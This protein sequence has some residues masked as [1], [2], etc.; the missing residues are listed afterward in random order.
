M[1]KLQQGGQHGYTHILI[2]TGG[3]ELAQ[4][5]FDH[6][7][8]LAK[9]LGSKV[10]IITATEPFP[11]PTDSRRTRADRDDDRERSGT[12][13]RDA[14]QQH[15][16]SVGAAGATLPSDQCASLPTPPAISIEKQLTG[17]SGSRAGVAEPGE[18]L[19]YT[20]TLTNFRRP[21]VQLAVTDILDANVT[22][23]NASDGGTLA[24]RNVTWTGLSVPG[25]VGAVPGTRTLV[26]RTKVNDPL[27]KGVSRVSNLAVKTGDPVPLCP[28]VAC[29]E[30]PTPAEVTVDKQ[31][32]GESLT[33]DRIAEPGE[34]LTYAIT[35]TNAGGT[36]FSNYRLTENVPQG[37][38]L[39]AVT[40]ANG[41]A[42]PVAG[43]LNLIVPTVLANNATTV[44][45]EFRIADPLPAGVGNI[46]NTVS[47]GDVPPDCTT[48]AVPV[49]TPA[50]VEVRKA[51]IQESIAAD[52]KTS[53]SESITADQTA[54]PG[55]VLTYTLTLTNGDG[56]DFTNFHFTENVPAGVT[57]TAVTGANGFG[58]PF[59]G[60]AGVN[61]VVPVVPASGTAI[62]TVDIDAVLGN[63]VYGIDNIVSGG[64]IDPGCTT[65]A[66]TVPTAP[67]VELTKALTGES[68]TANEIAEPGEVLTYTLTLANSGG[69]DFTDFDFT[70]TSPP[71]PR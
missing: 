31:L 35:L 15:C 7:L 8:S 32:I 45:V 22:F 41:F 23:A 66:V 69:V 25:Q 3:S 68:I 42:A 34:R 57:M 1:P 47:G 52:V 38:T 20:I 4:K 40:G 9:A 21:S 26:V 37:A 6:G 61:L 46:I 59:A 44:T 2:S 28:S 56:S 36:D 27:P 60:S 58:A 53:S 67:K 65:C 17:E 24:G 54:Q 49:P 51:L 50:R 71:A 12:G 19:T 33:A 16:V 55:E 64:D 13:R 10:T 18:T 11:V 48:C 43:P 30:T 62:V 63:G 5:G 39:V 14:D 70:K 29:V